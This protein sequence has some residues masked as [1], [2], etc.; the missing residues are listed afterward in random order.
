[1]PARLHLDSLSARVGDTLDVPVVISAS[2]PLR[3][4]QFALSF[5]PRIVRID[6]ISEGT[7]FSDWAVGHGASTFMIPAVISNTTGTTSAWAVVVLGGAP[8]AGPTGSGTLATLHLT[9]LAN[10][11]SPLS[12]RDVALVSFRASPTV[13]AA[14]PAAEVALRP[15][16]EQ[17]ATPQEEGGS[18]AGAGGLGYD[19]VQLDTLLEDGGVYVGQPIP[20]ANPAATPVI[21]RLT[22]LPPPTFDYLARSATEWARMR[23]SWTPTPPVAA[24]ALAGQP[25]LIASESAIR[26]DLQVDGGRAVGLGGRQGDA[27]EGVYLIDL[28]SGSETKISSQPWSKFELQISGN[29]VA[30]IEDDEDRLP[31]PTPELVITPR[32]TARPWTPPVLPTPVLPPPLPTLA[33][34][35]TP[36]PT[37]IVAPSRSIHVYNLSTGQETQVVPE[38]AGDLQDI[39]M[40][41]RTVVWD[42]THGSGNPSGPHPYATDLYGY[43]L[44]TGRQYPVVRGGGTE[45]FPQVSGDWVVYYAWPDSEDSLDLA[46]PTLRAHSLATGEDIALGPAWHYQG[47]Y[48]CSL[49]GQRV[50]WLASDGHD[51]LYDLGKRQLRLL[52]TGIASGRLAGSGAV[53]SEGRFLLNPDTG[54]AFTL[55]EPVTGAGAALDEVVTDGQSVVWS[56]GLDGQRQLYAAHLRR[57]P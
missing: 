34:A 35:G 17:R 29:Y 41:G 12:F 32:R 13:Q 16:L 50:V 38:A 5:D 25:V 28:A 42:T 11:A 55:P 57:L 53:L 49:S 22:V 36:Q 23:A 10:G 15:A 27:G 43:D 24:D 7:F 52:G 47:S 1:V 14:T 21:A 26:S 19:E 54:A 4:A 56:Y 44:A 9:V 46:A 51:R 8:G 48:F 45:L 2:L 20:T 18:Y 31:S 3:G 30:W 37:P 6:G 40:S 39:S 33:D